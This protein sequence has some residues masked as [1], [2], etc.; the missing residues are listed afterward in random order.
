MNY[1]VGG[2]L[3]L[4][5]TMFVLLLPVSTATGFLSKCLLLRIITVIFTVFTVF[6]CEITQI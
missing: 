4:Y 3:R 1:I 5:S 2:L 6:I